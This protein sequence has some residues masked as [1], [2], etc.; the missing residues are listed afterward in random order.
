MEI[1]CCTTCTAVFD[2]VFSCCDLQA[3]GVWCSVSEYSRAE[4][5][6]FSELGQIQTGLHEFN[7]SHRFRGTFSVV[8]TLLSR[9]VFTFSGNIFNCTGKPTYYDLIIWLCDPDV[10]SFLERF[11]LILK[12]PEIVCPRITG[13]IGRKLYN[14][15]FKNLTYFVFSSL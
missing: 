12:I 14:L 7:L 10:V 15:L 9:Y 4:A 11:Y 2:V 6:E 5:L 1:C 3:R 13:L 8:G